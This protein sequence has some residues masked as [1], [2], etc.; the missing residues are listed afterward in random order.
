V[1]SNLAAGE[2]SRSAQRVD[3]LMQARAAGGAKL[4]GGSGLTGK[5]LA[6]GVLVA[7]AAG[8]IG[9][10]MRSPA[11]APDPFSTPAMSAAPS[12]SHADAIPAP[13]ISPA[14]QG[15]FT[16]DGARRVT[17]EPAR[18]EREGSAELRPEKPGRPRSGSHRAHASKQA[19]RQETLETKAPTETAASEQA[20]VTPPPAAAP[21]AEQPVEAA[22]EPVPRFDLAAELRLVRAASRALD[23]GDAQA[24]LAQLQ[25]YG[26]R[27]PSGALRVEAAALRAMALCT[28]HAK[29]ADLERQHFLRDHASSALAERVKRAC[30]GN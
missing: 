26:A 20:S 3:A 10:S 4:V 23:R 16:A 13:A 25:Q 21:A 18:A 14:L 5:L 19:P 12:G 17:P 1:W 8:L 28:A 24:A 2:L 29:G 9:W 22:R 15:E 7:G 6:V 27:Y 11:P 30:A